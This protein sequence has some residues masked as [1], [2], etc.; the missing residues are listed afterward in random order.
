MLL[1]RI[2]NKCKHHI[3]N[4]LCLGAGR[5]REKRWPPSRATFTLCTPF[6]SSCVCVFFSLFLFF[7]FSNSSALLY[8]FF[9]LFF[10][11]FP[12]SFSFLPLYLVVDHTDF[13]GT[14]TNNASKNS[15]ALLRVLAFPESLVALPFF[16]FLSLS[17]IS[18]YFVHCR[19]SFSSYRTSPR[20][21][22]RRWTRVPEN[23]WKLESH[24]SLF[25]RRS[26]GFASLPLRPTP[27]TDRPDTIFETR[28]REDPR[29]RAR[30]AI[31]R[32]AIHR[33]KETVHRFLSRLPRYANQ[34]GNG[35]LNGSCI[36]IFYIR[37]SRPDVQARDLSLVRRS[38][39]F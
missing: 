32:D 39:S 2:Y 19:C 11:S 29:G 20:L 25:L 4:K 27:R 28:D 12:P 26:L 22:L 8:F 21:F 30:R 23:S 16:F 14:R 10:F 31:L 15:R 1:H 13:R 37:I 24:V 7:S 5:A 33:K 9:F 36:S 3:R 18:F 6:S 17:Q 35:K 34:E 38:I